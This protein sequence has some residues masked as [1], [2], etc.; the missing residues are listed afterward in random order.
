M[1]SS[2]NISGTTWRRLVVPGIVVQSLLIGGGFATGR[3]I[4]EYG[5]KFGSMGIWSGLTIFIGFTVLSFLSFEFSRQTQA[6]NYRSFFKNLLGP[7]W[8]LFDII[9]I[10][11]GTLIIAVM[12]SAT[13][14]ILKS[15][16]NLNYWAGVGMVAVIV[17]FLNYKGE[18]LIVR[19]KTIGTILLFLAYILFGILVV[20]Q[21]GQ[22]ILKNID[23]SINSN[24]DFSLGLVVWTGILYIGYNLTVYPAAL[25]TVR[26][27]VS[28]K[29]VIKASLIT[30]LMMCLPWFLTYFA[31]L[32]YYPDQR[33]LGA[34]VPWL[35]MLNTFGTIVIVIFG[36]VV[37]W[38]LIET[39]TGIIHAFIA[40]LDN[41]YRE[42]K[43]KGLTNRAKSWV[44]LIA[45]GLA[46]AL[47]QFGIIDLIAIGY[48]AMAYGMIVVFAIPMIFWGFKSM[49]FKK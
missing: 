40:R 39:A 6:F 34:S 25:F 14:E 17:G 10:L 29:D 46:V 19:F 5:A 38:T 49:I 13:G 1:G 27:L 33:V 12:A 35:Q 41:H 21:N 42:L 31:L 45:L 15:T 24:P 11:L 26:N 8:I 32:G 7:F 48:S 18:K 4:V 9:Y 3:E 16:L 43:N 37:G 23:L 44:S 22:K 47:A 30:G 28:K 20:S 2:E 36:I